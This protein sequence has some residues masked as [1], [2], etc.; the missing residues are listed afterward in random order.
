M[1]P[2][3]LDLCLHN[4]TTTKSA[5]LDRRARLASPSS[6]A[7]EIPP[8]GDTGVE[9]RL[10]FLFTEVRS[11][12]VRKHPVSFLLVAHAVSVY[13]SHQAFLTVSEQTPDANRGMDIPAAIVSFKEPLPLQGMRLVYTGSDGAVMRNKTFRRTPLLEHLTS[14]NGFERQVSGTNSLFLYASNKGW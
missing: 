1:A 6:S 2:M 13:I 9:I 14:H 8:R 4:L 10:E 12:P 5:S 11:Y 7:G 3:V